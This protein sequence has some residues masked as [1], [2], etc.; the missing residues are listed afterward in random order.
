LVILPEPG[1]KSSTINGVP[2]SDEQKKWALCKNGCQNI[3]NSKTK[4]VT[5]EKNK[6]TGK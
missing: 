4:E 3:T 2:I 1:P 5:L 6:K